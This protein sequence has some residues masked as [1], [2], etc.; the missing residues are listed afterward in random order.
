VKLIAVGSACLATLRTALWAA[1]VED[2]WKFEIGFL[3]KT[4]V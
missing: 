1:P 2:M 3:T 4:K